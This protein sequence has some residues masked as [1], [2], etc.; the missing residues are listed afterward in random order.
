M[1]L[2]WEIH[3]RPQPGKRKDLVTRRDS[4]KER[5]RQPLIEQEL[6]GMA[7][8]PPPFQKTFHDRHRSRNTAENRS[9]PR[10]CQCCSRNTQEDV[11]GHSERRT[12]NNRNSTQKSPSR[13][14][15][16][17]TGKW[18]TFILLTV[19]PKHREAGSTRPWCT[20]VTWSWFSHS[21]HHVWR[22]A[23]STGGGFILHVQST[24]TNWILTG[25]MT[26]TGLRQ[27]NTPCPSLHS[28]TP[29]L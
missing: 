23:T 16:G 14:G 11:I 9:L 24:S 21:R 18:D 12:N 13:S 3:P 25:S 1:Y 27:G 8:P 17:Y 20:P 10:N 4:R 7:H 5:G 22:T 26:A 19:A 15:P 6:R 29:R 28:R 2:L